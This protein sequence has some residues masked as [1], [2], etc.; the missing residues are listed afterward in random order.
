[1]MA[2][3]F[4]ELIPTS[5]GHGYADIATLTF[6]GGFVIMVLVDVGLAV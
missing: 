4:R 3:I 1:M 6:I 5:H 2:V